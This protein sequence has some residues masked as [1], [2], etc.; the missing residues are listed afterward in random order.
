LGKGYVFAKGSA[1]KAKSG[2]SKDLREISE[3][4]N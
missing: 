2:Q 3:D 1:K 4:E